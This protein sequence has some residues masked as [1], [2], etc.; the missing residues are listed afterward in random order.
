MVVSE[1]T[2]PRPHRGV[3][4]FFAGLAAQSLH[5]SVVSL[6]EVWKGALL[7]PDGDK[8]ERLM[9]FSNEDLPKMFAG[10]VLIVDDAV[11]REW[12]A[13]EA[14]ARRTLP[15]ADALIA[16]TALVHGL[17]V[18]TRNVKDFADI[19]ALYVDPWAP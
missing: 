1:I 17:T 4:R 6:A 18:I 10:R 8:R 5:I 7:L 3:A 9:R 16:A 19:G 14:R 12:G 11:A 2:K 13:M 15:A